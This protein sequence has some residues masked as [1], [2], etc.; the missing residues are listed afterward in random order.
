MKQGDTDQRS[1]QS[2]RGVSRLFGAPCKVHTG[3]AAWKTGDCCRA[4]SSR[5][6]EPTRRLISCGRVECHVV[7]SLDAYLCCVSNW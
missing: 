1:W 4:T 6:F 5:P 3:S 7:P 2:R